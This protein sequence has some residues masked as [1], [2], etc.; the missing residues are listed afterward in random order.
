MMFF[1]HISCVI[2]LIASIPLN[3]KKKDTTDT[4]RYVPY[5]D[6]HL[7]MDNEGRLGTKLYDKWDDFKLPIVNFPF[8]CRNIPVARAYGVYIYISVDMFQTLTYT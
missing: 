1:H 6:L 8:I 3:L 4:A 7:E 2:L 5:L